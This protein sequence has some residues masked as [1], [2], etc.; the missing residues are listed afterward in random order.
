MGRRGALNQSQHPPLF[1]SPDSFRSPRPPTALRTETHLLPAPEEEHR[2]ALDM[3]LA[4]LPELDL[5]AEPLPELE[6]ELEMESA[7]PAAEIE[8]EAPMPEVAAVVKAA[9]AEAVVTEVAPAESSDAC[10]D[11]RF[12][13]LSP[14]RFAGSP[15]S[16]SRDTVRLC[17]FK[18]V[19]I[20]CCI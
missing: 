5:N 11:G 20:W 8:V 18:Y 16:A 4:P 2:P 19:C 15:V 6:L 1:L 17:C 3:N 12:L 10:A 14:T 7:V 9:F 13:Q